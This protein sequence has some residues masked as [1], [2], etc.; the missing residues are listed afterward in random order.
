MKK[1]LLLVAVSFTTLLISCDD[2]ESSK[3]ISENDIVKACTV[4]NACNSSEE[5]NECVSEMTYMSK[6]NSDS[7]VLLEDI[8]NIDFSG[9]ILCF[10]DSNSCD[11]LKECEKKYL[12]RDYTTTECDGEE[13]IESCDGTKRVV[14][15]YD[16]V[17]EKSYVYKHDCAVGNGVCVNEDGDVYCR[18]NVPA[19]CIETFSKCDGDIKKECYVD[20]GDKEY[21]E[22]DCSLVGM[23]C[24]EQ[25]GEAECMP[26]ADAISCSEFGPKRCDG[27]NLVICYYGKEISYDCKDIY[28]DSFECVQEVRDDDGEEVTRYSCNLPDLKKCDDTEATCS[29]DVL[30]YCI[31]GETKD[32]NC[33]DNGYAG[34]QLLT[35]EDED[36]VSTCVY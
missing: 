15:R 23:E 10:S 33:K 12:G 32:F 9:A 24:V 30:K 27:S 35:S 17:T 26:K 5:I 13:F 22:N 16:D 36:S 29:G 25:D 19:E 8:G 34:C 21:E 28:G 6:L 31:N 1:L 18:E 3:K 14:C 11:D 2:S 20:E 7:P 4:M